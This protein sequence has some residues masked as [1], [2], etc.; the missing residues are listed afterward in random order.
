MVASGVR[1]GVRFAHCLFLTVTVLLFLAAV[2]RAD[3]GVVRDPRGDARASWDITR[4]V[5]DNGERKM[6]VQ[7]HYRGPLRP[8]Y[9]LGLL[10]NVALDL[11]SPSDSIYSGDFS[12]DMLRGSPDPRA[13]NRFD[14][15]RQDDYEIVRCEG[16]QL[17]VRYGRG[18]LEFV[19]PQ[20]CF[21][22]FA[23]RVR[24]NAYTYTPRGAADRADYI[25]FWGPWVQQ[26]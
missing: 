13:P 3:R 11:G 22:E 12:I 4:V 14:L 21:G 2:A 10:T 16:L 26:G 5:V 20:S 23:G 6:R 9:G 7:V 17:R 1:R 15:V 8:G 24:L 18:L 19:V 25:R